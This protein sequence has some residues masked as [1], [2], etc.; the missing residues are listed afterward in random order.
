[1]LP[2][3]TTSQD[4]SPPKAWTKESINSAFLKNSSRT[5]NAIRFILYCCYILLDY[6]KVN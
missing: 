2:P 5:V 1:M 6:T 3:L 4:F